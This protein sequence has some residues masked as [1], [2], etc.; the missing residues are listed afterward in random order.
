MDSN[1]SKEYLSMG[2]V[3]ILYKLPELILLESSY[4]YYKIC[5]PKKK[6]MGENISFV[7]SQMPHNNSMFF[8]LLGVNGLIIEEYG[9][10]AMLG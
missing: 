4:Y 10:L 6:K 5:I 1:G 2:W 7:T 3:S 9:F 8:D